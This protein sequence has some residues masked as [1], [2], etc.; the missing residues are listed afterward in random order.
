MFKKYQRSNPEQGFAIGTILLAVVLIAAIVSAISAASR[1][2]SSTQNR[3]GARIQASA[4]INQSLNLKSGFD[5]L[6]TI[7]VN[8]FSIVMAGDDRDNDGADDCDDGDQVALAALDAVCLYDS[9]EGGAAAQ[10]PPTQAFVEGAIN[11]EESDRWVL[12][13]AGSANVPDGRVPGVG[14]SS[15][16][17]VGGR[18][19]VASVHNITND[20]CRQINNIVHGV[21]IRTDPPILAEAVDFTDSEIAGN[22]PNFT[23]AGA[24]NEGWAEGCVIPNGGTGNDAGIYYRVVSE[25]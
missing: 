8:R 15:A 10:R 6:T 23:G 2:S 13:G 14:S 4:L 24:A 18:N 16:T 21:S 20:V 25:G 1:G 11:A 7:G 5:R 19:I 17:G 9:V 22:A 3:E 12:L